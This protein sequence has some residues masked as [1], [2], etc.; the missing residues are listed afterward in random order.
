MNGNQ[1]QLKVYFDGLCPLCS[2]EIDHYKSQAGAGSIDFI[3]ITEASFS[4]EAA[5]LDPRRVHRRFHVRSGSVVLDGVDAFREIWKLL[6]RYGWLARL[7]GY[8]LVKL[9]FV[10]G[11]ELFALVRPL[12]PRKSRGCEG[13][14]YCE[15]KERT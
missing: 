4:A 13:S 1:K 12:L 7:T 2:R 14:P 10:A 9:F 8:R 11:Y 3:D 6:P 5:G 15:I